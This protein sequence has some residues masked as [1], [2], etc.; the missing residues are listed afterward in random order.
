MQHNLNHR[1]AAVV[2]PTLIVRTVSRLLLV[3][4]VLAVLGL[5]APTSLPLSSSTVAFAASSGGAA[6]Q[7][8]SPI[9]VGDSRN[10]TG[11]VRF[12]GGETQQLNVV[13]PAV[14]AA[15]GLN[16]SDVVSAVVLNVTIVDAAAAGFVTVWPDGGTRPNTSSVNWRRWTN[17]TAKRAAGSAGAGDGCV[18]V[19][20]VRVVMVANLGGESRQL[21]GRRARGLRAPE[22]INSGRPAGPSNNPP[23]SE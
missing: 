11:V 4:M 2:A 16:T 23:V 7:P 18:G 14:R 10:A 3:S 19:R 12:A 21:G 6:Y 8:I 20:R 9:R 13:T 22:S 15:A 5:V 1:I 17:G